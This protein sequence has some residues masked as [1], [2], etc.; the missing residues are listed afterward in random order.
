VSPFQGLY[1][2][3][4]NPRASAAQS[5]A[6]RFQRWNVD[7]VTINSIVICHEPN[8]PGHHNK[9]EAEKTPEILI[10]ILDP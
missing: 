10:R 9:T 3:D 7:P 6:P 4:P 2:L 1:R 5:A 8:F